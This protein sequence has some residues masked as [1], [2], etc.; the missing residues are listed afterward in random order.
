LSVH[1]INNV[2]TRSRTQS[3]G[4][5]L[6][7]PLGVGEGKY[8]ILDKSIYSQ[9]LMKDKSGIFKSKNHYYSSFAC[10]EITVDWTSVESVTYT[11]CYCLICR[12]EDCVWNCSPYPFYHFIVN[13]FL[14]H[15]GEDV[16]AK[17]MAQKVRVLCWIMTNPQN[18]EKK[19][20]HVKATWGSRCNILLFMSS[21]NGKSYYLQVQHCGNTHMAEHLLPLSHHIFS[22][23]FSSQLSLYLRSL[24]LTLTQQQPFSIT[25]PQPQIITQ[26]TMTHSS[27]HS[28]PTTE[29]VHIK[30]GTTSFNT[31]RRKEWRSTAWPHCLMDRAL[32]CSAEHAATIHSGP[33]SKL[34]QQTYQR[35]DT[36]PHR[37]TCN[38]GIPAATYNT[39]LYNF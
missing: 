36:S 14:D 23:R 22:S 13:C 3:N 27:D 4:N 17:K 30:K 33:L 20:L 25:A 10:K 2:V 16:E 38:H 24:L 26:L 34:S 15:L 5:R 21:E 19:A 37:H 9:F 29:G 31:S 39:L 1:N 6:I 18:H 12:L 11:D 32:H 8:I 35:Q 7:G 28:R